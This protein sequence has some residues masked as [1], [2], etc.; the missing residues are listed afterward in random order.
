MT[1]LPPERRYKPENFKIAYN[2]SV[3][4]SL[5]VDFNSFNDIL[6]DINSLKFN[7]CENGFD[8]F[9]RHNECLSFYNFH[10]SA[11]KFAEF[12]EENQNHIFGFGYNSA[13]FDW[14]NDNTFE[15]V[16][17]QLYNFHASRYA[18]LGNDKEKYLNNIGTI[19]RD[20]ILNIYKRF[21]YENISHSEPHSDNEFIYFYHKVSLELTKK[22]PSS[23]IY[24]PFNISVSKNLFLTEDGLITFMEVYLNKEVFRNFI[25]S[26]Y[27]IEYDCSDNCIEL[28]TNYKSILEEYSETKN[29]HNP[30]IASDEYLKNKLGYELLKPI[31]SNE[32]TKFQPFKKLEFSCPL[33]IYDLFD[34]LLSCWFIR[35]SPNQLEELVLKNFEIENIRDYYLYFQDKNYWHR[36]WEDGKIKV[37]RIKK[38]FMNVMHQ[39]AKKS[40]PFQKNIELARFICKNFTLELSDSKLKDFSVEE[41][42]RYLKRVDYKKNNDF[43]LI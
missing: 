34:K 20:K 32:V 5:N 10:Y 19:F 42:I 15:N 36:Y 23:F 13:L 17:N 18:L 21:Y 9:L 2:P 11:I 8:P 30:K 24:S 16:M 14:F 6:M 43:D 31:H 1:W 33:H 3:Y 26:R 37:S 12:K 28:M 38:E 29:H 22:Y 27:K 41:V 39:F 35:I 25:K 7:Y 40:T 4:K